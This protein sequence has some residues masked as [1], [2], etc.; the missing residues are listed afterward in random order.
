M[1]S[2]R[3]KRGQGESSPK[4][5]RIRIGPKERPVEEPT[6]TVERGSPNQLEDPPTLGRAASSRGGERAAFSAGEK[7][8][9]RFQVLRL[10]ARGGMGEVY[11]AEDLELA[12]STDLK[13]SSGRFF[14][15]SCA[16]WLRL[17]REL[18]QSPAGWSP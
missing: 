7:V 16:A 18:S 15:G 5:L 1:K 11:A 3:Q 8:A 12:L 9:G 14:G 2:E 4:K 10:I 6:A 17:P 13:E